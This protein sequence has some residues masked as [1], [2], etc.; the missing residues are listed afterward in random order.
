MVIWLLTPPSVLP[1]EAKV[2][3]DPSDSG[4][5]RPRSVYVLSYLLRP[6]ALGS[7]N[8]RNPNFQKKRQKKREDVWTILWKKVAS[9]EQK[10]NNNLNNNLNNNQ[11]QQHMDPFDGRRFVFI[12]LGLG[13]CVRAEWVGGAREG[14][15]TEIRL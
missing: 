10:M 12:G 8:F 3:Y 5:L 2:T 9:S 1:E 6:S 14:G 7:S 4:L 13:T 15:G 11:W